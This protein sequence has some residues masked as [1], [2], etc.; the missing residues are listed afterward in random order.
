MKSDNTIEYTPFGFHSHTKVPHMSDE[1]SK[2]LFAEVIK[3]IGVKR[4]DNFRNVQV[5]SKKNPI[6]TTPASAAGG[7]RKT[8]CR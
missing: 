4:S 5:D 8:S 6:E 2:E 3:N 7:S 1:K